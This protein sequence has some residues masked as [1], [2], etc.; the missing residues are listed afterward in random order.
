MK[1]RESN[2]QFDFRPLKVENRPDLIVCKWHNTY[3]WKALDEGYNS[4]SN[5][6]FIGGLHTKLWASKSQE[7]K[8]KEFWDHLGV[9]G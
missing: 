8:F 2:C 5:L 6:I 7:S 1:G 4:A 9:P 3:C